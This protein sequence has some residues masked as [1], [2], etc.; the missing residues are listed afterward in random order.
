MY[1]TTF[2]LTITNPMTILSFAAIFAGTILGEEM[3]NPFMI[4]AGVFAGS[5]AWWLSLSLGVGIVRERLTHVHMA[6]IN[7]ISGIAIVVFGLLALLGK[8]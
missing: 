3:G 7:R 2:F 1:T 6:W 5:A 4:V 8:R